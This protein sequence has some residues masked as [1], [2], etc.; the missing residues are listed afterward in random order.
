MNGHLYGWCGAV[1][2]AALLAGCKKDPTAS[3]AG[4]ATVLSI[5]PTQFSVKV[6]NTVRV[7]VQVLDQTFTPLQQAVTAG[8]SATGVAT[9]GP[10][11]N[12]SPD[13]SGTQSLFDVRGVAVG[14]AVITFSGGGLQGS[15]QVT[16]TP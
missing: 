7:T 2:A 1:V 15:A 9:V 10:P 5:A 3:L 11:S 8:S 13:P 6:G 4:K 12:A 16:V 14:P